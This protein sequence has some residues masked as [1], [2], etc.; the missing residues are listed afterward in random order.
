MTEEDED[1]G[2]GW[3]KMV[4]ESSV[5]VSVLEKEVLQGLGL[6]RK[7]RD[8]RVEVV[9]WEQDWSRIRMGGGSE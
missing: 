5:R 6:S 9:V 8:G 1:D 4:E 7:Q 3:K 2:G